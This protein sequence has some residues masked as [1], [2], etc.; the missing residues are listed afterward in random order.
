ERKRKEAR[1][2]PPRG[3]GGPLRRRPRDAVG[4]TARR[5]ET[6][7]KDRC[8]SRLDACACDLRCL[9]V[10]SAIR[11]QQDRVNLV[12]QGYPPQL[13]LRAMVDQ[14]FLHNFW[15]KRKHL[16]IV[17]IDN[18]PHP[19]D[20]GAPKDFHPREVFDHTLLGGAKERLVDAE[21]VGIA[22]HERYGLIK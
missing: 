9:D 7:A 10:D 15:F 21:V 6:D 1:K 12:T 5:P 2:E 16:G 17:E 14:V 19:V 13:S 3:T 11:R 8:K 22:L 18:P 20:V 4:V